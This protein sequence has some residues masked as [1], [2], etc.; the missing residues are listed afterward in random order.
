MRSQAVQ[1]LALAVRQRVDLGGQQNAFGGNSLD[2]ISDSEMLTMLNSSYTEWWDFLIASYGDNY[3]WAVYNLPIVQGTYAY[4]LPFDFYK[5]FGVDLALDNT[6]QNWATVLP[7]TLRDRNLFSFPLQTALAYA[8]WQNM[9]WQIQGQILNFLPN[10]GPMP[11]NVRLL[12]APTCPILCPVLPTNYATSTAV[13]QGSLTVTT[14]GTTTNQVFVALNSGTTG[15]V[16]PTWN[17]PG[18]TVDND[19]TWAY[20]G[21]LSLYATTMD[22]VNGGDDYVILD[23]AI[24]AGVK[25]EMDVSSLM[26]QKSALA[27]RVRRM[28]ANRNAGDAMVVAGGFGQCEGG[29]GYGSYGFGNSGAW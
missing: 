16:H 4:Q 11:G 9:R 1:Q 2:N 15:A 22:G 17:V 27:E 24:K 29:P 3:Q 7:Y 19:I 5:E 20:Q 18:T 13:T 6:L 10:L 21:P 28:I 25:Q 8:G 23:A 26:T 14:A 12:Y